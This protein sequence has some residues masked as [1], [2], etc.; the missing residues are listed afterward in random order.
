[1]NVLQRLIRADG[2]RKTRFH[3]SNG[4]LCLS[5][6]EFLRALATTVCR[7][8]FQSHSRSPWLA[9]SAINYLEPLISGKR[10]FEFGSGMST[11]WFARRCKQVVS[12]ESNPDW[13]EVLR[14]QSSGLENIQMI[15]AISEQ[16]YLG[17]LSAFGG[18]FDLIVIDGLYR[19][20][21]LSLARHYL[22][23]EGLLV[24]DNTDAR[25]ELAAAAKRL[26]ADSRIMAFRG[27]APGHLHPH[28]TTIIR[29]VPA[30]AVDSDSLMAR[31]ALG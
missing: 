22:E 8:V 9:F 15:H 6:P 13:Y 3:T 25:P 14:Q 21:C 23:A 1:M 16:D 10:V 27:W 12:V 31:R 20:Q 24:V 17:V 7:V 4:H 28:E 29:D 5:P 30:E 18:K 19:T 26:F 11:L 2:T